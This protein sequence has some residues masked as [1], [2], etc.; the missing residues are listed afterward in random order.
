MEQF[1]DLFMEMT[2]PD[3]KKRIDLEEIIFQPWVT[4]ET[5]K[6]V[7]IPVF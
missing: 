6:G 7:K 5:T 3:P 1:K 2:N 4:S